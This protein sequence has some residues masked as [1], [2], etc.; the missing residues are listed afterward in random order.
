MRGY[1]PLHATKKLLAN[2][3]A[4]P[5]LNRLASKL[6]T[7]SLYRIAYT[8]YTAQELPASLSDINNEWVLRYTAVGMW[9]EPP[10]VHTSRNS[11]TVFAPKLVRYGVERQKPK[12][13][14][15]AGAKEVW[16]DKTWGGRKSLQY[17]ISVVLQVIKHSDDPH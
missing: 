14:Q 13:P 15:L 5:P 12:C 1:C 10:F 17:S 6:N 11:V 16:R 2:M 3:I 9:K 4:S 8:L 7:Q